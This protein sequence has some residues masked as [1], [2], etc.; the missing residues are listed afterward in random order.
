MLGKPVAE[1]ASPSAHSLVVDSHDVR[2][3]DHL[4]DRE[5]TQT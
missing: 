4:R 3:I 1:A 5:R 2:E